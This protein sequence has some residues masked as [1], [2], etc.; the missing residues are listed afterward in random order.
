[1]RCTGARTRRTRRR[2]CITRRAKMLVS[3]R[4]QLNS[5]LR[6]VWPRLGRRGAGAQKRARFPQS[7]S[8]DFYQPL[9]ACAARCECLGGRAVIRWHRAGFRWYG[10]SR[11]RVVPWRKECWRNRRDR[12]DMNDKR[13]RPTLVRH[14]RCPPFKFLQTRTH[15]NPDNQ[16]PF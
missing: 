7:R 2:S 6:G 15:P 11:R 9:S 14:N 5:A 16:S 1:M 13:G 10:K 3:Q 8:S 4:T 12:D